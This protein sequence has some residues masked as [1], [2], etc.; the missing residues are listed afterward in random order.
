M[1]NVAFSSFFVKLAS[2]KFAFYAVVIGLSCWL[3]TWVKIWSASSTTWNIV[4]CIHCLSERKW[5]LFPFWHFSYLFWRCLWC[6]SIFIF[7]KWFII[8]LFSLNLFQTFCFPLFFYIKHFSLLLKHLLAYS[9][10][11]FN[12]IRVKLSSTRCTWYPFSIISEKFWG[13]IV[14]NCVWACLH[15]CLFVDAETAISLFK[16]GVIFL[17]WLWWSSFNRWMCHF[18]WSLSKCAFIVI[19]NL[20]SSSTL[21]RV[22]IRLQFLILPT[23]RSFIFPIITNL[24]PR[25]I[26]TFPCGFICRIFFIW[27]RIFIVGFV[28]SLIFITVTT[29]KLVRWLIKSTLWWISSQL[30][31][32]SLSIVLI[33]WSGSIVSWKDWSIHGINIWIVQSIIWWRWHHWWLCSLSSIHASSIWLRFLSTYH[34][35]TMILRKTW[36]FKSISFSICWLRIVKTSFL[37]ITA[38]SHSTF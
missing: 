35:C 18:S 33:S 7:S 34:R 21:P 29:T 13:Y 38:S 22:A 28:E 23:S 1:S 9:F 6:R 4:T 5:L 10:V 12:C 32:K 26:R 37:T 11:L 25:H 17:G 14:W 3:L 24:S 2:A 36:I 20:L 8:L 31:F 15:C 30:R 27:P 19:I 16:T